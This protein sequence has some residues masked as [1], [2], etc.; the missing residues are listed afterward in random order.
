[1]SIRIGHASQTEHGKATNGQAGDQTKKEVYVRTYYNH[2]KGWDYYIECT[3][4]KLADK[5]SKYMEEICNNP[6]V[7]YDQGQRLT[8]YNEIKKNDGKVKGI[9]KC[10][11]DCSALVACAYIFAGLGTKLNPSCTTRNLRGA[12]LA[13][14][15]F[16]AYSD[17]NH[18][19]SDKLAKRGGIYLKEG[20]H[21]VM[22]LEN[23]T[24]VKDEKPT[25]ELA[26]EYKATTYYPKPK[27]TYTGIVDALASIGVNVSLDSRGKIYAKNFKDAYKGTATQNTNMLG[28][29]NKGKLKK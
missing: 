10:E 12:L 29:L 7:G 20:S 19:A 4:E 1:M 9:G 8:L 14:G 13:T 3:D 22:A 5:A 23:G 15:K 6:N 24:G 11:T 18:T 2:S 21:V 28:L 27:K 16:V 26:K 17:K 25:K